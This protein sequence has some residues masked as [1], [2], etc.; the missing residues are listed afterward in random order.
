MSTAQNLLDRILPAHVAP[1]EMTVEEMRQSV[2]AANAAIA[3]RA[4]TIEQT[5]VLLRDEV[6]QLKHLIETSDASARFWEAECRR[7]VDE[8]QKQLDA[9]MVENR[10]LRDHR[11]KFE[12]RL[13]SIAESIIAAKRECNDFPLREQ[14]HEPAED[15]SDADAAEVTRIVTALG[16]PDFGGSR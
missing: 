10:K 11:T 8:K 6:Q 15:V 2:D 14:I 12:T 5:N 1:R 13:N 9:A 7:L 4:T 16:P 3:E